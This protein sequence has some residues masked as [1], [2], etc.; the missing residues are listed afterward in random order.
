MY[1]GSLFSPVVR[2]IVFRTRRKTTRWPGRAR[3]TLRLNRR[4]IR[5]TLMLLRR[6]NFRSINQEETLATRCRLLHASS[7]VYIRVTAKS[8][9]QIC[10]RC[11]RISVLT[12]ER[13][14]DR[15]CD[16]SG[17]VSPVRFRVLFALRASSSDFPL[18]AL[19]FGARSAC[20]CNFPRVVVNVNLPFSHTACSFENNPAISRSRNE[21]RVPSRVAL[22]EATFPVQLVRHSRPPAR[23]LPPRAGRAEKCGVGIEEMKKKLERDGRRRRERETDRE[24]A[25]TI[26]TTGD[27]LRRRSLARSLASTKIRTPPPPPFPPGMQCSPSRYQGGNQPP[28]DRGV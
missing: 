2:L 28:C 25:T 1:T 11:M 20:N 18:R 4:L 24:R 7:A 19:H 6:G 16:V 27:S 9:V 21:K 8:R 14:V 5:G 10:K 22:R 23:R 12:D 26:T 17:D 15:D 13:R 3:C